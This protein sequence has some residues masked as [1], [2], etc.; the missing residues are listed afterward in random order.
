MHVYVQIAKKKETYIYIHKK[1][2]TFQ[3]AGQFGLCFYIQKA[4]HFTLHH[5]HD[6]LKIGMDIQKA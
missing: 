5:F 2:D 1:R 3:N 6:F 4:R